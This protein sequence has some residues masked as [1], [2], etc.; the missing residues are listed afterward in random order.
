MAYF[1]GIKSAELSL[2][3]LGRTDGIYSGG[4]GVYVSPFDYL[5]EDERKALA[6]AY[7]E[8]VI[9]PYLENGKRN[10]KFDP[11][12]PYF[13][14]QLVI[15]RGHEGKLHGEWYLISQNW[16]TGYPNDMIIILEVNNQYYN[17]AKILGMDDES[18]GGVDDWNFKS[19]L[20]IDYEAE[21]LQ[22]IS[23]TGQKIYGI[24]RVDETNERAK[25]TIQYQTGEYPTEFTENALS[26]I[27]RTYIPRRQEA[28]NLGVLR[29]Q[30][31]SE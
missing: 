25:I 15:H 26:Y 30:K 9:E 18:M 4:N 2:I 13:T 6:K 27:E 29:T 17:G 8:N 5:F 1:E 14:N 11:S 10:G 23:W 16:T 31:L 7:I 20:Q 12:Q 22:W 24:F 19:E 28:T 21:R 3:D